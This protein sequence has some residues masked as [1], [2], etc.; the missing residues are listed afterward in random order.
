VAEWRLGLT[1]YSPLTLTEIGERLC[2][3][4][5]QVRQIDRRVSRRLKDPNMRQELEEI[6]AD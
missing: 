6:L 5:E 4:K 3:P 1:G 2:I